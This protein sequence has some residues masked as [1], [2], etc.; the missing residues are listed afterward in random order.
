MD[1]IEPAQTE[2][3]APNVFVRKKDGTL[4]F[5][6]DYLRLNA[7]TIWASYSIPH[8]DECIDSLGDVNI[9][10]TLNGT[11]GKVQVQI[12]KEN[13]NKTSFSS[14]SSLFQFM[15]VPFKLN[16]TPEILQQAMNSLLKTSNGSLALST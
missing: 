7:V 13:R 6:V 9:F 8:V 12:A 5:F 11:S 14:Y 10:L 4:C 2:W 3:A 1:F 16:T 15:C